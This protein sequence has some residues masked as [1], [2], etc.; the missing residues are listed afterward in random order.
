MSGWYFDN[1]EL[2]AI[3]LGKV[4]F[5]KCPF[6]DNDGRQWY[7]GNTGLGAGPS[8]PIGVAEEDLASDICGE[9]DGLSLL[10][11]IK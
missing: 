5:K 3:L 11:S 4:E 8:P 10:F 6:C 1:E 7:D 2:K 9:C